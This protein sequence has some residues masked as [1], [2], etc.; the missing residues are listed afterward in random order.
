MDNF[1]FKLIKT[2]K[3]MGVTIGI[4]SSTEGYFCETS[5]GLVSDY[6]K[7]TQELFEIFINEYY[8]K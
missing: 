6:F 4:Y 8:G 5:Q 1:S 7:T 2:I 3:F